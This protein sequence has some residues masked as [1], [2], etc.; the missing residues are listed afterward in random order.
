MTRVFFSKPSFD[1]CGFDTYITHFIL[2]GEDINMAVAKYVSK[3]LLIG[4]CVRFVIHQ[5]VSKRFFSLFVWTRFLSNMRSPIIPICFLSLG[6][7]KR[8]R[9]W[10]FRL[11]SVLYFP[12]G[13]MFCSNKIT[14][15]FRWRPWANNRDTTGLSVASAIKSSK[16]MMLLYRGLISHRSSDSSGNP[17]SNRMLFPRDFSSLRNILAIDCSTKKCE[18]SFVLCTRYGCVP[19]SVGQNKFFHFL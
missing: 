19:K 5:Q 6:L 13:N 10:A 1:R 7:R 18:Y 8:A 14:L 4:S 12:S 16:M 3:N 17:L 15:A 2:G 11:I 9:Y